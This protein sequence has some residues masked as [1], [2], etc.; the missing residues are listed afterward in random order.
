VRGGEAVVDSEV[1]S[2]IAG[3]YL[4]PASSMHCQEKSI[5]KSGFQLECRPANAKGRFEAIAMRLG[6]TEISGGLASSE[7]AVRRTRES[8]S[9]AATP[10]DEVVT[11]ETRD[12]KVQTAQTIKAAPIDAAK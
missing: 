8:R 11:V 12:C 6:V 9:K 4:G 3:Q 7:I 10:D 2:A 1:C 5:D